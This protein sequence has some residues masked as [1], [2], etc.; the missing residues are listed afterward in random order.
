[1]DDVRIA[2]VTGTAG[3]ISL[4]TEI[5]LVK[6]ARGHLRLETLEGEQ[7][8]SA[9][10]EL[11]RS[12]SLTCHASRTRRRDHHHGARSDPRSPRLLKGGGRV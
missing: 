2:I 6:L 9:P 3:E 11:R 1:V 7:L 10:T 5:R 8:R 12:R 4:L